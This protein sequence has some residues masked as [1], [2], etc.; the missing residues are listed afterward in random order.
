MFGKLTTS[1]ARYQTMVFPGRNPVKGEYERVIEE[2][3]IGK[4]RIEG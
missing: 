3:K 4:K 2:L 1:R